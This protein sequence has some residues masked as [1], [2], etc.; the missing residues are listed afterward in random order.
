MPEASGNSSVGDR[1]RDVARA[2]LNL[3]EERIKLL[4]SKF[5]DV[6]ATAAAIRMLNVGDHEPFA[7]FAPRPPKS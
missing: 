7:V 4:M 5:D 1:R 6:D 2:G 3:S